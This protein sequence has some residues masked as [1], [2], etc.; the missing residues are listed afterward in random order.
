MS[1]V[2]VD[3]PLVPVMAMT[4]TSKFCARSRQEQLDVAD[5]LDAG[6]LCR[7]HRPMRLG[8]RQRDARRQHQRRERRPVR[9]P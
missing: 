3:L 7:A 6:S 5:D 4:G 8:M 9:R 2:V 1:A